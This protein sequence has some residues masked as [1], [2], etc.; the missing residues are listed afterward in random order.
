MREL[1]F[2]AMGKADQSRLRRRDIIMEAISI[3]GNPNCSDLR[4]VRVFMQLNPKNVTMK[5][6][7]CI[8]VLHFLDNDDL[9]NQS[10]GA[11]VRERESV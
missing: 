8:N 11:C 10:L 5:K 1:L 3:I 9:Y 6:G 2:K 4:H 7:L